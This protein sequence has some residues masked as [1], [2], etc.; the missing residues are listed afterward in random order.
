[1]NYNM[2]NFEDAYDNYL[3]EGGEDSGEELARAMFNAG[4]AQKIEDCL[5]D[6]SSVFFIG[7]V[8]YL[9]MR[10]AQESV[11]CNA[12][13]ISIEQQVSVDGKDYR[14]RI[15]TIT[16]PDDCKSFEQRAGE[17]AGK[18]L[19]SNQGCSV[20]ELIIKGIMSGY[21]LHNVKSN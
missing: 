19:A 6:V 9:G 8:Q 16:Y 10:L 20:E 11:K 14:T 2:D 3:S 12:C 5:N 17:I 4:M 13:D 1:M 7:F 21:D 15:S 18:I